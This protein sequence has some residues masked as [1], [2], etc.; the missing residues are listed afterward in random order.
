MMLLEENKQ[1]VLRFH[2]DFTNAA[3]YE[4]ADELI[5]PDGK[6]Y[7]AGELQTTTGPE[8]FKQTLSAF[9]T[10]FPDI[11]WQVTQMVAEGDTVVERV[12]ARGTHMG[13]FLGLPATGKHVEFQGMA[14]IRIAD[15]KIIEDWALPNLAHLLEQL[16][17]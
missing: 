5:H 2:N 15:G 8:V 6:L 17:S 10:A 13:T 11:T 1:L 9:K 4:A 7:C 12:T 3:I 14:M 16:R